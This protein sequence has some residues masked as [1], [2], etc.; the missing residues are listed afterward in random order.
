V[1]RGRTL[2]GTALA[3]LACG[4]GAS[5]AQPVDCATSSGVVTGRVT[6][7]GGSPLAGARVRV[8]SCIGAP[9][10]T[11]VAGQFTLP[12]PAGAVAVTAAADGFY[13][14]CWTPPGGSECGTVIA[15]ATDREIVLDPLPA[16][17]DPAYVFR[18]SIDCVACH[19]D[20]VEQWNRSTMAHTNANLWVDNL[21]NGTDLTNG[22]GPAPD[23]NDPPYFG[24]LQRH[25]TDAATPT[26]HG[27]C[28]N[29]HQ[30]EYVGPAPT[31]TS[32]NAY[33]DP[34]LNGVGCDFCHK[35]VDV[36]V[37]EA[38]IRR[39]NLVE[40][41]LGAPAK[42]TMLRSSTEPW[43]V[44][45]PL[46]DVAYRNT[47]EM[48]ASHG[49]VIGDSKLCASCHEDHTDFT[50]ANGDF[51]EAYEGPA[52]QMTYSEWKASAYAAE[53]VHCQDCH[54]PPT[55]ATDFCTV[56][57]VE[58]DPSQI[59][60]HVF[61]GTTPEFLR[62]AVAL[63]VETTVA[64][65][66]LGVTVGVANVGAGHHVPTGV[67]I[68]NMILVVDARD[69]DGV[70]LE[71]LSGPVVPNW[72]GVGDPAEGNFAA[73]PGKGYA[74]VLVD[75]F[76]VENVLFT[77]A[78]AAFD[79]RIPAGATDTSAYTFRLPVQWQ[80]RDV[81]VTVRLYYRRAFKPIADQRKWNV[82]L[83]GNA[84]GTRGD[85]TDYDENFVVHEA[86]RFLTCRAKLKGVRATLADGR[87]ALRGTLKLP[88]GTALDAAASGLRV[89]LAPEDGGDALVD[90][91][92]TGFVAEDPDTLVFTGD[93]SGA[94]EGVRLETKSSA[95]VAVEATI[96]VSAALPAGVVFGLDGGET[97]GR[98]RLRC[99]AKRDTV[100]CR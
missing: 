71:R 51:L 28:A 21:Y 83:G 88:K 43:V 93:G 34:A 68:R 87:L 89:V 78:V 60:S 46:D 47:P 86:A 96:G 27:E 85:G 31:N 23:P 26:R 49:A 38:G 11:D 50:D 9:V 5:L 67:T 14:G 19:P 79:N 36:D 77:E 22:R 72:G 2:A 35:V 48:R 41:H 80:K 8:Q 56:A 82:P 12:V 59:H 76:L 74:R 53:G 4:A 45:G 32:F 20:H 37:S 3:L 63:D 100:T 73:L 81:R 18:Q 64:D 92:V 84:R 29:C 54:M 7:A 39:P 15:G 97:C 98:R 61:E 30:P 69:R 62:R 90:E 17:D 42:T 1:R 95:R 94:V 10:V 52:S 24:F 91:R 13:V 70:V 33:S 6:A 99:K 40:G 16:D 44:F 66:V 65:D 58:R 75:E 25:N 55:G 57:G